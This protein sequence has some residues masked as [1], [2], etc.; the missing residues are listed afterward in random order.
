[1]G[2]LKYTFKLPH[3][4]LGATDASGQYYEKRKND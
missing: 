3:R 2:E 4:A 1:M